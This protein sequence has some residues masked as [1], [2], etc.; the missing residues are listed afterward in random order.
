M[1]WF[2]EADRRKGRNC[3]TRGFPFAAHQSM[4]LHF[5]MFCEIMYSHCHN[6]C[7]YW[8]QLCG[9]L[10]TYSDACSSLVLSNLPQIAALLNNNV[11]AG[12]VCSLAGVC[13]EKFH[14]HAS[15]S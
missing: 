10:G 7:I 14:S 1:S 11:K 15:V 3:F 2:D 4:F 8:L 13:T 6:E 9:N 12:P 5:L